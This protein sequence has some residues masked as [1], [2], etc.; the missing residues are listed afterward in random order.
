MMP[1][2]KRCPECGMVSG[3]MSLCLYYKGAVEHMRSAPDPDREW[4]GA[5]GRMCVAC[6][7]PWPCTVA[8]KGTTC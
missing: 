8:Q 4:T 2:S 1:Q 5:E 7:Q 3:H 6:G